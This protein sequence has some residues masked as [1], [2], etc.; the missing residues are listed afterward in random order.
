MKINFNFYK[1]KTDTQQTITDEIENIIQT[2]EEIEKLEKLNEILPLTPLRENVLDWYPIKE[3]ATIL[4]IKGGYGE[5]TSYLCNHARKVVTIEERRENAQIIAQRNFKK[6]NLE[7]IV[8]KIQEIQL[9]EKFDY[10]I[11][12]DETN[13]LEEYIKYSQ[14]YL[15]E[16]G[17]IIIIVNN[18][19]G[20]HAFATC[21]LQEQI[22]RN[23]E[24]TIS[25]KAI[26]EIL[27]RQG[28]KYTKYYYP[29][30]DYKLANVIFTDKQ[31]PDGESIGR[32]LVYKEGLVNFG[33]VEA[34]THIIKNDPTDF[35]YFANSY[36]IETAKKEY[37]DNE[38]KFVSF[39]NLRKKEKRVKTTL[40]EKCVY[41]K[42]ANEESKQHLED[43]KRNIDLLN[44]LGIKILDSYDGEKIISQ[45]GTGKTLDKIILQEVKARG[46]EIYIQTLKSYMQLLK[47]KLQVVQNP[48]KNIFDKYEIEYEKSEVQNLTFVKHGFFDLTFQNCFYPDEKLNNIQAEKCYFY[49][50]E[51]YEENVPV[52]FI[53]Y[54][55]IL[56]NIEIKKYISD[57]ETFE[58]L[59]ISQYVELLRKLDDKIQEENRNSIFWKFHKNIHIESDE[60]KKMVD[61][62]LECKDEIE[63]EKENTKKMIEE[64]EQLK[65]EIED[66][67]KEIDIKQREIN[68]KQR[69]IAQRD[70]TIIDRDTQLKIIANSRSWK[71]TKPLRA[72]T[73]KMAKIKDIYNQVKYY[74]KRHGLK[75]TIKKC[76]YILKNGRA[77]N[78]LATETEKDAYQLW[79]QN[80]EPTFEELEKQKEHK[81]KISPKISL[82]VPMYNTPV[83]FFE[84]LVESLRNQT[85]KNWELCLA[86]GSNEKNEQLLAI[87]NKDKRIKYKFLNENKQI[88]GNTNEAIKMATGDYIALFDHDDL[89]PEF[90]LFEIVKAINEN[91]GVEFIYTDEDKIRTQEEP[92]FDPYFK[93]DF[94][95]DT[96]RANNY[97]CHFSVFK[98]EIMEHKTM[99]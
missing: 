16:D 75:M 98:K 51:W 8:G 30:P 42:N 13:R 48:E 96:L 93:P 83:N 92:R 34:Y 9:K 85:Y 21:E 84:E 80:N 56:Y 41:K 12:V 86:D 28:L 81:F 60:Y 97:I 4:E 57:D 87:I 40:T 1:G 63:Q 53:I 68:S 58:R 3:N 55:A 74:K 44:K 73:N 82:I 71:I 54:R 72:I 37:P 88:A 79:I 99:I 29:M 7:I 62:Y 61:K 27:E 91:P 38:I 19:F 59:E 46:K 26:D 24:N 70:S 64:N 69:E 66:K 10:I 22:I 14:N 94:S 52:E 78:N 45:Y 18:K 50:Q 20:M 67:Q 76:I 11:I 36:F 43:I 25:K 17:K 23:D 35:P 95:P 77:V 90:S 47:N 32:S 15:E 33:E 65:K 6:N 39:T 31:L 49:D 89:L 5:I 2:E